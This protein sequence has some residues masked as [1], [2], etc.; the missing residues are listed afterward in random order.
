MRR[1][2]FLGLMVVLMLAAGENRKGTALTSVAHAIRSVTPL[3]ESVG[4]YEKFELVVDLDAEFSNPYDPQD[5]WLDGTFISPSGVQMSV[6]GFYYRDFEFELTPA[7]QM[8]PTQNWSWRVRF[9][10]DEVGDWIYQVTAA[11]ASSAVS[12]SEGTFSVTES[13][14]H[15]FL[16]IDS[17]NPRYIVFDDGTPYFAVGENM[18]WYGSGG[19]A[20]YALWLDSLAAS[21]GNFIRVWFASWGF[22]FEWLDTG[23]GNYDLRQDR[24]YR[25]DKL[26]EMVN[27]RDIYIMLCLLNHGPFA[28]SVNSEWDANPYNAA[29]G[30]PLQ[31]P[32]DFATHPEAER[33]WNQKLRYTAARW[34]YSTNILAWEWWNEVNWTQMADPDLLAPWITRSAAYLE[35]LDPYNHLMTHSGS[36]AV[37]ESIWSLPSLDFTQDHKYNMMNLP[38]EFNLGIREWRERYPEKPFLMGEFGTSSGAPQFDNEGVLLHLGLWSAPMNGAFGTAMTWWWD[39]YIHPNNLYPQ[40]RAVAQFFAGEDLGAHQWQ[41]TTATLS[42]DADAYVYGLQDNQNALLW[43]VSRDYSPRY[44]ETQY[45]R[46]LRNRVEN[47][48]DIEFPVLEGVTITL[49]G[50]D[51]GEYQVEWWSPQTGDMVQ[52]EQVSVVGGQVTLAAAP[53]ARDW[54]IKVRP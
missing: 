48:L 50:L 7:E 43:L 6:P 31:T 41:P 36:P 33:L 20:D 44:L 34:G 35:T 17:R 1:S 15:G 2:L 23:L 45:T 32:G 24:A 29:N 18:S 39:N 13:D 47:P 9:T 27:E 26:F 4:R 11:T 37:N 53:F 51:D 12:S 49:Q 30:G 42:E 21:G 52:A 54:A 22:N 5:I 14:S 10:P 25:M 40:F 8:T 19:M 16:R 3:Q 38:R 46:N 28:L